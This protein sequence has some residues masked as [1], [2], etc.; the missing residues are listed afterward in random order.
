MT[1]QQLVNFRDQAAIV[2]VGQTEFSKNSGVSTL[3]LALNAITAALGDAGLTAKDVDGVACHRVGDSASAAV[4]AESLG[5]QD[6][7]Y[8]VDQFGGGSAS[9]SVVGNA[10]MAV[11]TGQASCV[12]CW[13]SVN[14]RS[15]FRM[16]GS[17]RPAPDT[18]E[19]QYQAP[20]GF[21]AP[22]QQFAMHARAYMEEVG[23]TE[24]DLGAVAMAHRKHAVR[25]PR[26]LMSEPLTMDAY[27]ESRWIADPL[28]LY[29]CSLETDAA[30]AVVV[31]RAD[32]AKDLA[33]VPVTIRAAC[34]GSGQTLYSNRRSDVWRSGASDASERLWSAAGLGPSE[35]DVAQFYDA[36]TPL[37][38]IALED[39]GFC[40]RGDAGIFV[41]S[42]ATDLGGTLPANTHGG[43][44][45]AGYVHGLDH[46]VEAV[47]QLRGQ[48]GARQVP[49]A[50]IALS[51]GQPGFVAGSTSALVL[52]R[53]V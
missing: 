44:L 46:L 49:D 2:G 6:L 22:P 51:T 28:R 40:K 31:T 17:N 36:F 20:F 14:A 16:G 35:V 38:L 32:R 4:V 9:H 43:H 15:E 30:V 12:V 53:A 1:D 21:F 33:S 41:A 26:A 25:N 7:A 23:A 39:Y 24:L 50:E 34:W 47:L 11:A 13:R 42:G 8:F 29:D 18:T 37:V 5:V 10:A 27:L 52:K 45:S 48:C 3:T 19:S